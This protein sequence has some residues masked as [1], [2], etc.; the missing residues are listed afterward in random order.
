[1]RKFICLFFILIFPAVSNAQFT[2]K[3]RPAY[4]AG[5]YYVDKP[6]MLKSDLN[7]HLSC[8]TMNFDEKI[9]G[10]IA[11]HAGYYYSGRIA[12]TVY[13]HIKGRKYDTV[14][15]L[16]PSHTVYFK[17]CS[18]FNGK[19]Y[20]TP[21]G[22]AFTDQDFAKEL[23]SADNN[24]FLSEKGHIFNGD[25]FEHSLEIQIPFLLTV[26]KDFKIVAVV[27][28]SQDGETMDNLSNALARTSKGKNVLIVASSDLSHFHPYNTAVNMDMEVI[29]TV[30]VMDLE[31]LRQGI[32]S[33]RFETCGG[34]PVYSMLKALKELGANDV[35]ITGYENSGD[36]MPSK[37]DNVVG[38]MGAVVRNCPES[39]WELEEREKIELLKYVKYRVHSTVKSARSGIK[40]KRG[41]NLLATNVRQEMAGLIY[42]P[43]YLKWRGAFVT[44]KIDGHLRG[45]IGN[46]IGSQ[47]LINSIN[48]MA[49]NASINDHRFPPVS[50]EELEK[51][52]YEISILSPLK[53]VKDPLKEI[54]IGKHGLIIQSSGRS[55][56]LLPQV[57]VEWKW[58]LET[59]LKQ[60]SNKAGLPAEEWKSKNARLFKFSADVFGK[61]G[62]ELN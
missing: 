54:K 49:V 51:L 14:V 18:V 60:V 35:M 9:L 52:F 1:M 32:V 24:L 20:D 36:I 40:E 28:G 43:K 7:K 38:Y 2:N 27:M 21:L 6:E 55:G 41:R 15:I 58:D 3:I 30:E 39:A 12:G 29:K 48:N 33:Q 50:E 17:G 25:K 10:I 19:G 37:K 13:N 34:G 4:A 16:S 31:T 57:P 45:C 42:N 47:P 53:L 26:L 11:P 46:V 22:T 59:F 56:L 44:L 23:V 5:A 62:I 61:K 8:S